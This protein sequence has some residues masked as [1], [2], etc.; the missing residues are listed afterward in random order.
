PQYASIF[1]QRAPLPLIRTVGP[2]T[3]I[4]HRT[5]ARFN[6]GRGKV[7]ADKKPGNGKDPK[8]PSLEEFQEQFLSEYDFPVDTQAFS[9]LP[10]PAQ[11]SIRLMATPKVGIATLNPL[12]DIGAKFWER[13][14]NEEKE[15]LLTLMRRNEMEELALT[16][17]NATDGDFAE[18]TTATL[19]EATF[20][21]F[22]TFR[23]QSNESV[24]Q[25]IANNPKVEKKLKETQEQATIPGFKWFNFGNAK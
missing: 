11:T 3:S 10:L 20:K 14:S 23:A 7:N 17:Y 8:R 2:V 15:E 24:E 12:F 18:I 19:A 5:Y 1:R 16:L 22:Q 4:S 25:L 9:D 13:L 6:G 21:T